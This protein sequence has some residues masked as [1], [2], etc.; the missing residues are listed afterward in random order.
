MGSRGMADGR[1][2]CPAYED[3]T[4]RRDKEAVQ[5]GISQVFFPRGDPHGSGQFIVDLISRLP[6]NEQRQVLSKVCTSK[7]L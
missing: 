2:S 6:I 7:F 1:A 5:A 3:V 4:R